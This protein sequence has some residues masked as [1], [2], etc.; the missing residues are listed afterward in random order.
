MRIASGKKAGTG[1]PNAT[2]IPSQADQQGSAY[3]W[4]IGRNNAVV[5]QRAPI[6][7]QLTFAPYHSNGIYNVGETVGWSVMPGPATPSYERANS[8]EKSDRTSSRREVI[9]VIT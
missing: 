7:Q 5:L 8:V 9:R 6:Q 1:R 3:K 2:A 4:T